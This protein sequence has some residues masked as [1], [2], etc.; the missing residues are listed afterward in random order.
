[1][2]KKLKMDVEIAAKVVSHLEAWGAKNGKAATDS[3][4]CGNLRRVMGWNFDSSKVVQHYAKNWPK[5]SGNIIYPVPKPNPFSWFC[6]DMAPST[7][8]Y[9]MPLWDKSRYAKN[10][11]E[12]CIFIAKCMREDYN[13]E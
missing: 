3:G 4:I 6:K 12:L 13:I 11:R 7:A 10:R 8:Y 1:M 5:Y 2:T 9:N